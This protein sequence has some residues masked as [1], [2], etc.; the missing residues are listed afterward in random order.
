MTIYSNKSE[1]SGPSHCEL[2]NAEG[3]IVT[4]KEAHRLAHSI[5][6][7]GSLLGVCPSTICKY[8][9]LG[10]VHLIRF[11]GRTLMTDEELRRILKSGI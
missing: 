5:F 10:R 2:P 4:E 7:A 1:I 6:S 8:A 9:K 11:G 3:G